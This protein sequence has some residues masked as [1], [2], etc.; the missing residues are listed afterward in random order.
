ME[1]GY[2]E[3]LRP[4]S[5]V[6]KQFWDTIF[7]AGELWISIKTDTQLVQMVC[8]LLDRREVLREAF[9][10]DPTNRPVNMSLLETEKQIVNAFSLLGFT[11]ADRTRLGLVSA[12]TKSKLEELL[13]RKA[14]Q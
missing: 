9:V 10:A 12:K 14:A 3:P 5:P 6:G 7:G 13:A 11:P 8:E 1:Y 4:L 2:I